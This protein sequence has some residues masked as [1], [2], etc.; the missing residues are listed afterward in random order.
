M[1]SA[2]NLPPRQNLRRGRKTI[3]FL[4][5]ILA[6]MAVAATLH[7][8]TPPPAT[9]A[10]D[11]KQQTFAALA[12][13]RQ[14]KKAEIVARCTE[15]QQTALAIQHDPEMRRCFKGLH[16]NPE[17]SS[18]VY[19]VDQRFAT[20][21]ND[22]YDILFVDSTGYVFHSVKKEQDYR[23]NLFTGNA[24]PELASALKRP[25]EEHFVE[26]NYY[27]P[28]EEAAAFFTVSLQEG[29]RHQGWFILQLAS[30]SIN[31]ILSDH[32][33]LG[34]TGEVYLVNRQRLML[35]DSRF[36]EDSTILRQKV[37]TKAV[38]EALQKKSGED[39]IRDY[40]G[41]RVF[42]SYEKFATLGVT[43]VI[44]A[45]IDEDE[46]ITEY[47]K[48][49]KTYF[50]KQF[51]RYLTER[52][53]ASA[54]ATAAAA[55]QPRQRVDMNE[56]AKSDQG[57]ELT[58]RGV[59]SCT[60]VAI[61]YPGRFAY[62]AH[63][64]PTDEIYLDNPLT[65][66]FL[67]GQYHNFLAHLLGKIEHFEITPHQRRDLRVAIIAVHDASFAKA[68]DAA[69][70][71]DIELANITF[72]Y[73]PGASSADITLGGAGDRLDVTWHEE[74]GSMYENGLGRDNLGMILKKIIHYPT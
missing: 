42:S 37:D 25:G 3:L 28:S 29:G 72:I 35:S 44:I 51:V 54:G 14:E 8:L 64:S 18:L 65:K 15:I 50:Q 47:Y 55:A 23:T 36:L 48:Q 61:S 11:L 40:R 9:T 62:L 34:R 73:N 6:L 70:A 69:L 56:F 17:A 10:T 4:T 1:T 24:N 66:F 39:I 20:T 60:A 58:T 71:H 19:A 2:T 45:E 33:T 68:V 31:A 41:V 13:I 57:K 21:Y 26:F 5:M 63:I 67:Q 7:L 53:P 30:N 46:V 16:G 49:H 27:P 74:Q 43:W 32:N 22:F 52:P 38:K 12:K 59:A